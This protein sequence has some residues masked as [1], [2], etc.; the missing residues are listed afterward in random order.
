[1][2]RT[3][4]PV[5]PCNPVPCQAG[6]MYGA[7]HGGVRPPAPAPPG[8]ARGGGGWPG[9]SLLQSGQPIVEPQAMSIPCPRCGAEHDVTLFQFGQSVRC[10]CGEEVDAGG[11][12]RR[13]ER[14]ASP[15]GRRTGRGPC[16]PGVAPPRGL[17][18]LEVLYSDLPRVDLEIAIEGLRDWVRAHLP[19]RLGAVRDGL[20]RPVA[21]FAEQGWERS[22]PP[23]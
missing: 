18:L 12:P 8:P 3:V 20:R 15:A 2:V 21:A 16:G 10:D 13:P 19:D 14:P 11:R 9:P 1:M 23:V 7:P 6:V 5:V 17:D 22:R 4:A